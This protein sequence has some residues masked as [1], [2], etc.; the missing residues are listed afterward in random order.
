[1]V[2]TVFRSRVKPEAT[3][4]YKQWASRLSEVAKSMPGYLSHKG[5]VADDGEKL[6]LVEFASEEVIVTN[7]EFLTTIASVPFPS[8]APNA[9]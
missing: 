2:I 9:C 7:G 4:E 5:V 1:M 3:E 8:T 6:T